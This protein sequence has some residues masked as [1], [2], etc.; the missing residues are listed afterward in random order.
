MTLTVFGAT[1]QVGRF[2]V[3]QALALGHQVRAFGR[4][5]TELIDRDLN[6]TALTAIHGYV[7]D[8]KDVNKAVKGAD[9]VISVLGGSFDGTDHT[10]SLGMKNII[11]QM[12]QTGVKRMVALGGMGVLNA[13]EPDEGLL[14]EQPG[15]PEEYLP[16][17][18]E[19]LLAYQY[20]AASNL[21]WTFIC[22]PDIINKEGSGQYI[23]AANY[24]PKPNQYQIA[25]GDLASCI[26]DCIEKKQYTGQRV[27]IS[28]L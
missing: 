5:V 6:N 16:V 21:D 27:G 22:A 15:Y 28:R 4:N 13:D 1:G 7:F 12:Q 26:L 25:A 3:P 24:A 19:H 17:G 9:A 2:I 23:T 18:R 20:L 14:M 11:E 10:R 8:A